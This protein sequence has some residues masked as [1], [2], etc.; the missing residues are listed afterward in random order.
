MSPDGKA[1]ALLAHPVA[2]GGALASHWQLYT[3]GADGRNW[4]QYAVSP[5]G[6][7]LPKFAPD[8]RLAW[9]RYYPRTGKLQ[10]ADLMVA[11][12][13]PKADDS[14]AIVKAIYIN[15]YAWSP[16]GKTIVYSS[17][18]SLGFVEVATG[19]Q[20]L[21]A[22]ADIDARLGS[23]SAWYLTFSPSGESVACCIMFLGDRRQGGPAMFGDD[24]VFIV[25][26]RDKASWFQPGLRVRALEWTK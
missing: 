1:L 20:Q 11:G 18:G 21:V 17:L 4:R 13:D 10:S 19:K 14:K 5:D 24:E 26:R 6:A 9:L 22:L 8:G 3:V 15:D 2:A 25:P 16:D 7:G 12:D 23:D